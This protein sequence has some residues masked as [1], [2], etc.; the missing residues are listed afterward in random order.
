MIHL[1]QILS[2]LPIKPDTEA[3]LASC[4]LVTS[5]LHAQSLAG[6]AR[7]AEWELDL[8]ILSGPH[9]GLHLLP[10]SPPSSV[11]PSAL[12]IDL[13]VLATLLQGQGVWRTSAK[14]AYFSTSHLEPPVLQ[15]MEPHPSYTEVSS[16]WPER[17]RRRG[18]RRVRTTGL[19]EV[20]SIPYRVDVA[21]EYSSSSTEGKH[22]CA[23][24]VKV[25]GKQEGPAC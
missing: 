15:A 14:G 7:G 2:G 3:R 1:I 6:S 17:R 12:A 25:N 23:P 4:A 9:C 24:A 5:I 10:S 22:I 21:P 8:Y 19:W 16:L 20:F 13:G 11:R 18:S